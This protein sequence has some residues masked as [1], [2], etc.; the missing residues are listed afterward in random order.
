MADYTNITADFARQV[1]HYDPETGRIRKFLKCGAAST[2]QP[3]NQKRN[4]YRYV[5]FKKQRFAAHR[6]AWLLHYGEWPEGILDHINRDRCD[7][8]ITNLRVA[9]VSENAHNANLRKDNTSGHRGVGWHKK[10]NAWQVRIRV[11]GKHVWLGVFEDINDAI[12]A[13]DE[14]EKIHHPTKP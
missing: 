14:A 13:R 10:Q 2:R 5:E 9:T 1:F 11:N 7:N 6:L 3:D 4:G 12:A 8:R